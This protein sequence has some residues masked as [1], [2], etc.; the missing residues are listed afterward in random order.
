MSRPTKSARRLLRSALPCAA[1]LLAPAQAHAAT[2][3]PNAPSELLFVAQ[4][5]VL[6]VVGRLLGELMLRVKQ[7]AVMGQ[8]IAGL[9]LGPSLLG[10]LLPDFQHALFPAAKEQK[11]MLDGIA[12]FGI[13]MLLLLTGM[14]TD[15]KLV[16]QSGRAA[17]FASLAGIVLPFACGVALGQAL[18]D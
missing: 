6:M 14:E 18:P 11:A 5:A 2:G 15:L 9:V 13:L 10:A 4:V 1:A 12:Q 17:A 7:P 16:R 3:A 8:L